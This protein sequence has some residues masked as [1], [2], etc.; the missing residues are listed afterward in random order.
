MNIS[1]IYFSAYLQ[2]IELTY[3]EHSVFTSFG[4][5][6]LQ[7]LLRAGTN[8]GQGNSAA[9]V[10]TWQQD[11]VTAEAGAEGSVSRYLP[12][13]LTLVDK[14][15]KPRQAPDMFFLLVPLQQ[16]RCYTHVTLS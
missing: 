14:E 13:R 3:N 1:V 12:V 7:N 5:L 6:A 8:H 16:H 11:K 10:R 4:I 2:L 9:S 15:L